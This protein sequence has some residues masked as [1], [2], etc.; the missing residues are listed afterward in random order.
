V[1]LQL[2]ALYDCTLP[3]ACCTRPQ[4]QQQQDP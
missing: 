1:W 4:Q 2:Y 3:H